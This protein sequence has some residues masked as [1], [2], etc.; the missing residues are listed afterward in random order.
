MGKKFL[1][2]VLKIPINCYDL[3]MV[4]FDS[5]KNNKKQ[6]SVSNQNK[7]IELATS[8]IKKGLQVTQILVDAYEDLNSIDALHF[9]F[10]DIK[11]LGDAV[12]TIMPAIEA[13]YDETRTK[14]T[15]LRKL[16]VFVDG[17]IE[18]TKF[19]KTIDS[20]ALINN[21]FLQL[22]DGKLVAAPNPTIL[23]LAAILITVKQ[24]TTKIINACD[25][26]LTFLNND[27]ESRVEGDLNVLNNIVNEYKYNW[28]N[29]EYRT[30]HHKL[31]LDIKRSAEQN[32]IFYQ[33]QINVLIQNDKKAL[34]AK[35]LK[36]KQ[37]ELENNFN[38][39]QLT[40]YV[41]S[42]AQFLEVLLLGNFNKDYL[43]QVREKLL[44][45][46]NEYKELF[47]ETL[48]HLK[49]TANSSTESKALKGLGGLLLKTKEESW[50]NKKGKEINDAAIRQ[51]LDSFIILQE[52][53]TSVFIKN[54]EQAE[55]LFNECN[56]IYFDKNGIYFQ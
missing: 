46:S 56:N 22:S 19:G 28:D 26:I 35:T 47:D 20:I 8:N 51:N 40:I 11:N 36:E 52:D 21:E 7:R 14:G 18:N 53:K 17:K 43:S 30:S 32:I 49:S 38:Y 45:N 4:F 2:N 41:Y 42:F 39:Y 24:E 3:D 50:L 55:M 54:I 27:K 48:D 33:K 34:V 10:K 16:V 13:I 29:K 5:F 12:N 25:K 15:G 44:L 9:S 6:N 37:L 23:L 1:N 31:V